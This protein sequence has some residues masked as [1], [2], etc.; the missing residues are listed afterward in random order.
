MGTP[1]ILDR[2]YKRKN[3]EG[4]EREIEKEINMGLVTLYIREEEVHTVKGKSGGDD[5]EMKTKIA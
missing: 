4:D 2:E 3:K 5:N 1:R